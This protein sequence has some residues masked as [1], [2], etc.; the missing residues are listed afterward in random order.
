MKKLLILLFSIAIIFNLDSC[1]EKKNQQAEKITK[2]ATIDKVQVYYFH[3]TRRCVTCKAVGQVSEELIKSKYADN[4]KV[5]FVEIDYD[6][7]GNDELVDKFKVTSSGLYV[8][9]GDDNIDLTSF[10]FQYARTDP[11]KLRNRLI[12]LIDKNL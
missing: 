11:D 12:K 6:V 1:D 10:A 7:P 2:K 4:E 5:E 9:N 3:G 8:Y